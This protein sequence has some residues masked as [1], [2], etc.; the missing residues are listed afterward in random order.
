MRGQQKVEY[1]F[2]LYIFIAGPEDPVGRA[3]CSI[4]IGRQGVAMT[5]EFCFFKTALWF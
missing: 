4:P 3:F 5:K 1:F 2:H